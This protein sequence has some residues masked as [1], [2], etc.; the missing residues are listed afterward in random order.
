MKLKV[1]THIPSPKLSQWVDDPGFKA[2]I[3][4]TRQ[5][6]STGYKMNF[7]GELFPFQGI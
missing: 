2:I 7:S 3:N 4:A 1:R 6:D 5:N